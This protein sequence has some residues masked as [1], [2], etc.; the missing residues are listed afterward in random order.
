MCNINIALL[1][2]GTVGNGVYRTIQKHKERIEQTIGVAVHI[3]TIVI[4][5]PEKHVHLSGDIYVTND[6]HAIINNPEIDIVFEAIVG[7]EPAF[8]YLKQC[9]QNGKHIITANKEMFACHGKTLKSLAKVHHVHIGYDATTA[10]GIPIIQTIQQLLHINKIQKVEAILNG[11]SNYM[12]T[13][14]R[15]NGVSFEVALKEAQRLGYAEADPTND[16][17]GHDAF[18]KL[19]ILSELIYDKQPE[20]ERVERISIADIEKKAINTPGRK[21]KHIATLVPSNEGICASV[22]PVIINEDHPLYAIEGVENAVHI[23]TDIA[24]GLTI[25]GAGAGALPTASAMM[26][27]FC[28]MMKEVIRNQ[29]VQT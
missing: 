14:M 11:T 2:F 26:E 19:M 1:G 8:S 13:E 22:K 20:W 16:I 3:S 6:I 27:D 25:T 7:K 4:Q 5:H 21:T 15:E 23:E 10:G 28:I 17:A 12:L 29:P 9:I 24:G 18:F